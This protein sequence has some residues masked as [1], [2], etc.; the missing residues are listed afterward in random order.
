MKYIFIKA[1]KDAVTVLIGAMLIS[2]LFVIP[3]WFLVPGL[4]ASGPALTLF[5]GVIAGLVFGVVARLIFSTIINRYLANK[6]AETMLI[7]FDEAAILICRY[8]YARSGQ[9]I[10]EMDPLAFR[11]DYNEYKRRCLI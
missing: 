4:H 9:A 5:S 11:R 8:Q 2:A 6:L 1:L 3:V 7:D 10:E